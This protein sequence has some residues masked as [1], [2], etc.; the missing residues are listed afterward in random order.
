MNTLA[1]TDA[2]KIWMAQRVRLNPKN[3]LKRLGERVKSKRKNVTSDPL[4]G[5]ILGTLFMLS[6]T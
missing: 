4:F 6:K 1:L 2:V 3:D 5:V